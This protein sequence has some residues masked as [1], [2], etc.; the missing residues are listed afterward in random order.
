[1]IGYK[2]W[3]NSKHSIKNNNNNNIINLK[4]INLLKC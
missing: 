3:L 1:M 2:L 4:W